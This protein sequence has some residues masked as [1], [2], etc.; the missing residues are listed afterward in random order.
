MS[1]K[2]ILSRD[3]LPEVGEDV[4]LFFKDSFH[5]HPSRPKID[6]KPAWRCNVGE[7]N[8]PEGDWAIEGRLGNYVIPLQD[9]IAWM[10][11]PALP[12]TLL[13]DGE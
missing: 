10:P 8:S 6:V 12:L 9:G 7:K 5:K 13:N 11:L 4:I 1:G 2:W 3:G